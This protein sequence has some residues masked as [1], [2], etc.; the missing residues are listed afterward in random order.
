MP[1]TKNDLQGLF[2]AIVTPLTADGSVDVKGLQALVKFQL[3]AGASGI[4]PIGG[5]G[6][7]PAFSRSERRDIVAACVD[8][9]SGKPVIP[10]VLSTGF[11]DALEAGRDFAAAGAAAVMTVTPYY[12]P[13]TQEGMREYFRKYRDNLDLPVMLYQIPRRTTV[14]AMADTVQAMAED[15]SIIGMKY[16][17]Y[18]MPDFIR[19]VKHCG[20]KIA[21]L[22]GEE[23]LF[24]TH[25]AL[26]AQGG[27]LAS[28]TIYPKIWLE[29]F[30]LAKQGKLKEALKL[31]DRIDPVVDSI[32][33]ETNPGPLKKYMEMVGMP[34]G[35]VRL[36]LL[37]PLPETVASM[38]KAAEF[39]KSVN[40]A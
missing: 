18:D 28:A 22:S 27:V 29:I 32:Y 31:Q 9:A 30:A 33:T 14:A 36:P 11:A 10:G 35:G 2:T 23:P 21:I 25:I 40:L 20:D 6:E 37:G 8:A 19:T 26:G 34:V 38:K 4:V 13:G 7:Y 24:A 3:A 16:S 1:L 17:S 12:A 5:T 15:K 39:A